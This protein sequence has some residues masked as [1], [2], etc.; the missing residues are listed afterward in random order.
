MKKKSQ[1]R[2]EGS[3]MLA[4]AR[5]KLNVSKQKIGGSSEKKAS[6]LSR[7]KSAAKQ[8]GFPLSSWSAKT[9]GKGSKA[10]QGGVGVLL[11]EQ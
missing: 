1:R 4:K 5:A 3:G 11:Q 10:A 7:V 8:V 2:R 6:T 9:G